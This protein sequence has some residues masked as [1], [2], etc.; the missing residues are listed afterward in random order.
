MF[1]G[2]GRESEAGRRQH[3]SRL[4]FC[5]NAL[6]PDVKGVFLTTSCA[7]QGVAVELKLGV[8]VRQLEVLTSKMLEGQ[9]LNEW[10]QSFPCSAQHTKQMLCLKPFPQ[11]QAIKGCLAVGSCGSLWGH[12]AAA[13]MG[14]VGL[15]GSWCLD[16]TCVSL[17]STEVQQ[18]LPF[19]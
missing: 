17:C 14:L 7:V 6:S 2:R 3:C 19:Q 8:S 12:C 13:T 10:M 9:V 11:P 18:T 16:V 4:V 1:P 5:S 15:K